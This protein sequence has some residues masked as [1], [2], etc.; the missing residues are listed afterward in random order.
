MSRMIR[1]FRTARA[2]ASLVV[3]TGY[4][5]HAQ[6]PTKV[7]APGPVK[8]AAIPAFQEATLPNG[9]RIMLVESKRQPVVSLALMLP[10]GDSYDPAGKEGLS[11][12]VANVLTKGAGA[13]TADQVSSD[14][15]GVGGSI[16]AGS[17]EDFMTVRANVLADNAP[18][19]F[20]LVAD[21]VMRPS[22]APKE[23]ELARTQTLSALQLEQSQ[24]S[25]L[26][27]RYFAARLFGAHP[28]GKHPTPTTVRA[29]TNDDLRAFQKSM[30]VPGGALLVVAGDIS[31]ARARDL[32]QRNFGKWY[33]QAPATAKRPTPPA[34]ARTEILLVHRP[35]SVQ[36][37]IV[38]GN[39][40]YAP[41]NPSYYATTVG[42]RILGGGSD[43]RLFK[44]LREQKSWTYGAYSQLTR[45]KD[46]GTFAATAEVRNAVT[47]SALTELLKIERDLGTRPSP[48][49]EL[50]AAKGGLVG[51]LPLQLETAQGIAEQVGRYTMLGLPTDFIRTLRPRLAAVTAP[52]VE[53]AVKSY[54][55]PDQSLIVVVGD[56]AQIYDKLAKIA[57]TLIV[58]AQGDAMTP[59]D[60]VQRTTSLPVDLTKITERADSFTVLVQGNPLGYQTTSL[61]KSGN[62]YTYRTSMLLGPIMQQ[63]VETSFANDLAP[64]SVKGS[65]KVQG[66][67]QKLDVTY[68]NGRV[69]GSAMTPS[70]SGVKTVNVDTTVAPGVLDDNMVSALVPG[71]K[72]APNAKFTVSAF[73]ASSGTIKQLTLAV[74]AT[75]SV[76]VPAGTFPAYRVELTG[77][78]QPLTF[79]IT[80]AEP[81]RIVK[82]A[83]SGAPVEFVLVK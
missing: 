25:S 60:L 49:Q 42:S 27:Q 22:F 24:P 67:E 58:N 37:N 31:L 7:P 71:L 74:T 19:A 54:M 30:L 64:Q 55:R 33:G 56:G 77:G 3:A 62:G 39:L 36:S 80:T 43:G 45:N 59:A 46:I 72:W 26:A 29:L 35:G 44:T 6:M 79:F 70:P 47:D 61:K 12:M 23:V 52:Q 1:L 40:T 69:K 75:E 76:T 38:V 48:A 21:A 11:S 15:E 32:A 28:Y 34:R 18:L 73:D 8:P 65:G 83:F 63:S 9:L 20:E 66:Q 14:I 82:M 41:N 17:S 53:A 4:V 16:G 78:E 2:A 13:R 57:P 10:A 51:S 68:A 81:Y 5:A 50:D